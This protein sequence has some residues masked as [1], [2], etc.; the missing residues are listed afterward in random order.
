MRKRETERHS[1]PR[2]P[3][4]RPLSLTANTQYPSSIFLSELPLELP[5]SPMLSGQHKTDTRHIF[6]SVTTTSTPPTILPTTHHT[7]QF[8]STSTLPP[9]PPFRYTTCHSCHA[10]PPL[11]LPRRSPVPGPWSLVI[12]L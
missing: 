3:L 12:H 2:L 5:L 4:P 9:S 6:P 1:I 7:P 10:Y 8:A 11:P